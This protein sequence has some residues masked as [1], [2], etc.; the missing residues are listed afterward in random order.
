MATT[1]VVVLAAIVLMTSTADE[2]A[3]LCTGDFEQ[4]ANGRWADW[5][6]TAQD[7]RVDAE[8]V[9][10]NWYHFVCDFKTEEAF[11]RFDQTHLYLSLAAGSKGS[12]WFDNFTG[13]LP[14]KNPDFEQVDENGSL[15][16]WRQDNVNRTI[17][18]DEQRVRHGQRSLRLTHQSKDEPGPTR[19]HQII[20]VEPN[21]T[22][23]FEF[24]MFLSDDF[25]GRPNVATLCYEDD[26][27]YMGSPMWIR[28]AS[29]TEILTE[30]V[31][32]GQYVACM[33][34]AGGRAELSQLVTAPAERNLELTAEVRTK[35]LD[36]ALRMIVE[37]PGSGQLFAEVTETAGD[38][39][40]H[41]LSV[42][43]KPHAEAVRIGFVGEGQG[44]IRIDNV[45]ITTPA[46]IPPVQQVQWLPASQNYRLPAA[47]TVRIVGD[48]GDLLKSG[49]K[50]LSSDLERF[51]CG[52][53]TTATGEGN[54]RIEI[55]KDYDVAGHGEESYTLTVDS[56]GIRIGAEAEAG[57]FYGLMTLLQLLQQYGEEPP[58]V[59]ACQITDYPDMPLR[60]AFARIP[61][62]QIARLKL[63]LAY[64]STSYWYEYQE[65]PEHKPDLQKVIDDGQRLNIQ[66]LGSVPT[67][68]GGYWPEMKN[69]H[70]AEGK[71]VQ[72]EEIV[73]EAETAVP[74][75]HPLLIQ[76]ELTDL[77]LTSAD[78][79][80]I[81]EPGADYRLIPGTPLSYPYD[82]LQD[83]KPAQVARIA[84]GAIPNGATVYASYDYVEP[85]V[86][87]EY[88]PSDEGGIPSVAWEVRREG[89]E[90]Y[91]L[92]TL[93]EEQIAKS[94][95]STV[96]AEAGDWLEQLRGR[97]DWFIARDMPP[98][99]YPWDGPE[100]YPLC[101]NFEPAEFSKIRAKVI[102]YFLQ[103]SSSAGG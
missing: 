30:R 100:L 96:A 37:Q 45:Q 18:S 73:L 92:L 27:K 81:Y 5:E 17:F 87:V 3:H 63:N 74:L 53:D 58:T 80:T 35:D 76:T 57:A 65:A 23:R 67:L 47:L 95:D 97:V 99:L 26:G 8:Q 28:T 32:H 90:D 103:L 44:Q 40:W 60:G 9:K 1:Y 59:V 83:A 6:L 56:T 54:L 29:W 25:D 39:Q 24:D 98:S 20:D 49:L 75:A 7:A 41:T 22:Y 19:V 79:E 70:L 94:P 48:S 84:A 89:V 4:V 66:I 85:G 101:P 61:F 12:V 43:F 2:T 50:M 88:C 34:L 16:G 38:S 72:K 31:G 69:P 10:G 15:I 64:Y 52:L 42:R 93:L 91:R 71:W 46:L 13:E 11:A 78:G 77:Q 62:E 82:E 102:D 14:I 86:H 21:R 55:G 36:G 68:S 33:Q 51:D